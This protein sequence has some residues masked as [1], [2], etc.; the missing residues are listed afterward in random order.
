MARPKSAPDPY[1]LGKV[2]TL[3]YLRDETQQSIAERLSL[4]RPTVSRLLREA[5]ELGLVRITV[6]APGGLHL[7][8][9]SR[10][11]ER[12][13]LDSVQVVETEPGRDG[14]ALR[15]ELGAA[16]ADHLART[17][18]PGDRVGMAWGSTLAAMV[19]AMAPRPV[20]DARV[21]QILGGLGPPDAANHATGLVRKLARLLDARAVPLPAP[22][23]VASRSVR[24]ALHQDSHVAAALGELG[25]L[26]LVF[27]GVGSLASNAVLDDGHSVTAAEREMLH[28][29]GAV[30]DIA[31]RFFDAGG[32][33][34]L[35][36]LDDRIL[37]ITTDQLRNAARVVAVAGGAEKV[38]AIAAALR[39][40]LIDVLITDRAT[41][42][43]L[44]A[45][46]E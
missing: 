32:S 28:A 34:V 22:G 12:Y 18:R 33:P 10:L 2:S 6:A 44:I 17:V 29:R 7:E 37:G 40:R 9:E 35:T 15:R 45:Y 25:S 31:L 19:A 46:P 8:L 4:S 26:N 14:D 11:E 16:A 41:A 38:A 43:A 21:V 5:R 42:D 30:A 36:G 3:Y 39:T 23:V 20:H 13:G 27:V 24:D 1:L